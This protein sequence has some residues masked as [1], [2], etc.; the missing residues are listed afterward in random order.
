M[1]FHGIPSNLVIEPSY[2]ER[3]KLHGHPWNFFL[4]VR[5]PWNSMDFGVGVNFHGT[6]KVPCNPMERPL[7]PRKA[8]WISMESHGTVKYYF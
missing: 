7:L 8:P 4:G 5:I 2:M 6:F 1:K 3:L